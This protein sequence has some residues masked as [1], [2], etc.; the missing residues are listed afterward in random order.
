MADLEENL[1]DRI[2]MSN[3]ESMRLKYSHF[4]A[5]SIRRSANSN[6]SRKYSDYANASTII[7]IHTFNYQGS[8]FRDPI[9]YKSVDCTNG[10]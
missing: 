4:K 6:N 7:T 2:W 8:I 3:C 10:L 5:S 9:N 1:W